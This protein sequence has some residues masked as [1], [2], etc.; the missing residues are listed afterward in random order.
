MLHR[1]RVSQS[2]EQH[3]CRVLAVPPD[4]TAAAAGK[5]DRVGIADLDKNMLGARPRSSD[6][7]NQPLPALVRAQIANRAFA[8][9]GTAL[10]EAAGKAA[11]DIALIEGGSGKCEI[12]Q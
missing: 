1:R 10:L 12:V 3:G 6:R 5:R 7:G 8:P 2:F 9:V 4:R 11:A